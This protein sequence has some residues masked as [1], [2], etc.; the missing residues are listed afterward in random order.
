MKMIEDNGKTIKN[1]Q[2]IKEFT[3]HRYSP[4]YSP[5]SDMD[6]KL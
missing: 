3:I 6:I 4:L 2:N 5:L 1:H